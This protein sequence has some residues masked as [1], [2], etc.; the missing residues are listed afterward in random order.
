MTILSMQTRLTPNTDGSISQ[1]AKPIQ[2]LCEQSFS[3]YSYP[4]DSPC[5][6]VRVTLRVAKALKSVGNH[7]GTQSRPQHQ[8]F[9]WKRKFGIKVH[10][11]EQ[12]VYVFLEFQE[13]NS[14]ISACTNRVHVPGILPFHLSTR[15]LLYK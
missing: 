14:L 10:G 2:K 5:S 8:T 7:A 1:F 4:T 9:H 15:P 6:G 11:R 12:T 13:I 3:L